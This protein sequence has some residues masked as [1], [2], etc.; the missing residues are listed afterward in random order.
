MAFLK[1]R[2]MFPDLAGHRNR[3]RLS[4]KYTECQEIWIQVHVGGGWEQELKVKSVTLKFRQFWVSLY[5]QVT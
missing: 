1:A 3:P 2:A 5:W 4:F